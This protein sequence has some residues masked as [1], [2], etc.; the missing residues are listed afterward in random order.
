MKELRALAPAS[1][2]GNQIGPR[3]TR[4]GVGRCQELEDMGPDVHV[5]K[6]RERRRA[7]WVSVAAQARGCVAVDG[8]EVP[9]SQLGLPAAVVTG[10]LRITPP[11]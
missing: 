10:A 8:F 1:D 2:L 3:E 11:A 5:G 7:L 4:I 6:N 9:G